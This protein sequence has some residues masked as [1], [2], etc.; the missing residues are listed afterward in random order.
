MNGDL[1][2]AALLGALQGATEFLPVSSSGH[3]VVVPALLGWDVPPLVFDA[4]IHLATAFSALLYFRADWIGMAR[5]QGGGFRSLWL[6]GLA[7]IPAVVVGV[8]FE[9]Q[10]A[11]MFQSPRAAAAQL[12]LTAAI[13]VAAEVLTRRRSGATAEVNEARALAIGTA[14]AAA[15]IPGISRSASTIAVGMLTGLDRSTAARFGFLMVPPVLLGAGFYE[16]AGALWRN[17]ETTDWA[18]IV[19]GSVS[20]FVVGYLSIRWFMGWIA[21]RTLMVFAAYTALLGTIGVL[22]L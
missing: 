13:L 12:W 2:Q 3:L 15:I 8:L 5:N 7:T 6:L 20:A 22:F 18:A 10:I 1:V 4:L 16:L 19:V 11:A 17:P 14:Q 9:H 21:T